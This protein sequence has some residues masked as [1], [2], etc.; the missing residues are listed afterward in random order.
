MH[1]EYTTIAK[2]KLRA[3][4]KVNDAHGVAALA[5]KMASIGDAPLIQ[6]PGM[7]DSPPIVPAGAEIQEG[8]PLVLKLAKKLQRVFCCWRG[9]IERLSL[10]PTIPFPKKK[11]FPFVLS[12][13]RRVLR[14]KRARPLRASFD[15][16]GRFRVCRLY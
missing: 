15:R 4:K 6:Q 9:S 2:L 11:G 10:K 16:A 8:R 1:S 5:A 12:H 13:R 7:D 14:L 3:A